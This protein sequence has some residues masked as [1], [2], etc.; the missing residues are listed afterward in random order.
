MSDTTV[1]YVAAAGLSE[2]VV[3]SHQNDGSND[4]WADSPA[5]WPN[6]F[7]VHRTA[8]T[9]Q[10]TVPSVATVTRD[11]GTVTSLSGSA[12]AGTSSVDALA[13]GPADAAAH[14]EPTGALP[15]SRWQAA[16]APV[17][18]HLLEGKVVACPADT[19]EDAVAILNTARGYLLS[20]V[21]ARRFQ[22]KSVLS[23]SL[24]P[25]GLLIATL[26]L[27]GSILFLVT[28]VAF[29][30]PAGFRLS[31][32]LDPAAI[33]MLYVGVYALASSVIVAYNLVSVVDKTILQV[34]RP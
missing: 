12:L 33:I 13:G 9:H 24:N 19:V 23:Y 16:A 20:W 15:Q 8:S 14:S 21:A 11:T 34:R 4:E 6:F 10:M 31:A 30:L 5:V 17:K 22:Q 27:V 1:S 26:F 2:A 18:A 25:V 28:F 29:L 3:S 32:F 7:G